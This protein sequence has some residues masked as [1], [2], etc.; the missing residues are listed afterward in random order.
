MN[1]YVKQHYPGFCYV[2]TWA[3][4]TKKGHICLLIHWFLSHLEKPACWWCYRFEIKEGRYS[5]PPCLISFLFSVSLSSD[6]GLPQTVWY[7]ECSGSKPWHYWYPLYL[8]LQAFLLSYV[9]IILHRIK[10]IVAYVQAPHQ[11]YRQYTRDVRSVL[12]WLKKSLMCCC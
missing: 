12:I 2:E 3:I 10:L 7:A 1:N 8:A 9:I 11:S 5:C 4:F 6:F